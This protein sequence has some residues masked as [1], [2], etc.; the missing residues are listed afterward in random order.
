MEL[1][2]KSMDVLNYV[3]GILLR[4]VGACAGLAGLAGLT[5]KIGATN[6]SILPEIP[7]NTVGLSMLTGIGVLTVLASLYL[8][9]TK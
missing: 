2:L 9:K 5:A 6:Q 1:I 3:F 7:L 8:F 4:M